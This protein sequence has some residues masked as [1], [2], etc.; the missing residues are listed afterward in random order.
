MYKKMM[1]TQWVC[2]WKYILW[3]YWQ[4]GCIQYCYVAGGLFHKTPNFCGRSWMEKQK[5]WFDCDEAGWRSRNGVCDGVIRVITRAHSR[6][7]NEWHT[8]NLNKSIGRWAKYD[9]IPMCTC[10][11]HKIII[12]ILSISFTQGKRINQLY[13]KN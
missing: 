8:W 5:K 3:Q 12:R 7:T 4:L 6:K 9:C 10:L 13:L 2:Q 1:K 11:T